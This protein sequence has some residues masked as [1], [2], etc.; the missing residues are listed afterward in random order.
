MMDTPYKKDIVAALVT[1]FRKRGM[2]IGFYYSWADLHDP[3][4]RWDNRNMF[5]DPHYSK[6][7]NPQD[8]QAFLDRAT[9]TLQELC[10]KYGKIDLIEFDDGFPKEAWPDLIRIVKMVR[11]LQPNVLLRDRGLGPYGDFSTPE[12]WVP[13]SP[14]DVRVGQKPWE[15][16]EMVGK[17]WAYQPN[18]VYKPKEWF[19]STLVDTAAKGGNF[20]PGVSPMANGRFPA[21]TVERLEYVGDWLK[22]NGEAIYTTRRWDVFAEGDDIR[23]TRSRDGKYVYAISLKWPGESLAVESLRAKEG[24]R[25]ILLGTTADLKW[26]QDKQGL[27]IQIPS[28]IAN[29]KPCAQAYVFKVEAQPYRKSYE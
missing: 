29:H 10:T 23:F 15:A 3:N 9:A 22:V 2:G 8:W 7:L 24:S 1:A 6:E 27:V 17:R 25:I 14:T 18:D 11:G 5:Y 16:I 4:S 28:Q 12:H 19:V 20:M 13:N 21:E 26:R